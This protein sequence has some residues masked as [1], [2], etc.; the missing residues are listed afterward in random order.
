MSKFRVVSAF[1]VALCVARVLDSILTRRLVESYGNGV[2]ELNVLVDT[3]SVVSIFLSPLPVVVSLGALSL[4]AW[5]IYRSKDISIAYF[6]A[7]SSVSS[8]LARVLLG[9]PFLSLAVIAAAVMQ[10]ASIWYFGSSLWPD[11]IRKWKVENSMLFLFLFVMAIEI[12]FGNFFRKAMLG[13][14]RRVGRSES[15]S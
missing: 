6:D 9:F 2:K 12:L 4:F 3:G 15:V 10:N 13:I 1:A 7:G 5:M 11:A 14:L 8:I